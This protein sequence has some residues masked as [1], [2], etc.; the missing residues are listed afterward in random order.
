MLDDI[1]RENVSWYIGFFASRKD[2]LSCAAIAHHCRWIGPAV[3]TTRPDGLWEFVQVTQGANWTSQLIN[4][5][6]E[7]EGL[8]LDASGQS[9]WMFF[10]RLVTS[11]RELAGSDCDAFQS[12][13]DARAVRLRNRQHATVIANRSITMKAAIQPTANPITGAVF[14]HPR[15]SHRPQSSPAIGFRSK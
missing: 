11:S 8:V 3:T 2:S 6:A 13:G 9:V 1:F 7:L 12:S 10:N 15:L 5:F 14:D 4:F